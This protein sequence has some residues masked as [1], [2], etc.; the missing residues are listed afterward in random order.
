MQDTKQRLSH[1]SISLHWLIALTIISLM[2]VGWYMDTYEDYD[3]YP[4]HKSIGIIIF[5]FVLI[6]VIWRL[7]NGWPSPLSTQQRIEHILAKLVHWVL[8]VS[9]LLFPISG[10]MMSGAGGHGLAVFGWQL[11]AKNLDPVTGKTAPLNAQ[12]AEIGAN[13]HGILLW[14]VLIALALHLAGVIKH[15]IV[16]KDGT[17]SRMLGKKLP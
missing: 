4:I 17:L 7:K 6:R 8:L 14:V 10:M 16:Y 12:A 15:Q 1:I 2:A 5:V 3:L 13:M 11:L 9:T